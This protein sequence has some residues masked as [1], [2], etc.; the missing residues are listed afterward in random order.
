MAKLKLIKEDDK[1]SDTPKENLSPLSEISA[2]DLSNRIIE[3]AL[4][5]KSL[6]A[7]GYDVREISSIAK[8]IIVIS[9]TSTRHVK[10]IADKLK[11][12][13]LQFGLAP[14]RVDGYESGDWIILDYDDVIAHVFFEPQ[15]Q[16]YQFDS[17]LDGAP[18]LELSDELKKQQRQFKTGLHSL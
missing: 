3:L 12:G 17:L 13:T 10:G 15:R 18:K 5:Q 14:T 7:V 9:G 6:D 2:E 1:S 16:Y 8:F 11:L 4:T